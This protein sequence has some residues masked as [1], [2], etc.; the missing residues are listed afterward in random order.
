VAS[1]DPLIARTKDFDEVLLRIAGDMSW[2]SR[3][4]MI[5]RAKMIV[6]Q[7]YDLTPPNR[8]ITSLGRKRDDDVTFIKLRVA[9]LLKTPDFLFMKA[10]FGRRSDG[11]TRQKVP[12]AHPALVDVI[13]LAC[14][15]PTAREDRGVYDPMPL[16]L[17]TLAATAVYAALS[18]WSEGYHVKKKFTEDTYAPL[19]RTLL[20]TALDFQDKSKHRCRALLASYTNAMQYVVS[21]L[22]RTHKLTLYSAYSDGMPEPVLELEHGIKIR[23]SDD[24]ADDE[25]GEY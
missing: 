1:A 8:D 10:P 18:C 12:F 3:G 17:V 5:K 25:P 24:S 14:Y 7:M 6:V 13:W 2:V 9:E 23:E 11:Q 19:Y 15:S 21:T 20:A 4:L 22:P 16:P